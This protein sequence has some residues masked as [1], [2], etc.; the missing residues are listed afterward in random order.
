M[1]S[2]VDHK[3][4]YSPINPKGTKSVK[5]LRMYSKKSGS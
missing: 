3:G 2:D 5:F 4:N 1:K